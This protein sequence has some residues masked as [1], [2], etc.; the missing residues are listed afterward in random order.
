MAFSKRLARQLKKSF[1]H[2]EFEALMEEFRQTNIGSDEKLVQF[3]ENLKGFLESVDDSYKQNEEKIELAQRSLEV[4]QVELGASN[5]KLFALNQTFDAILNS[6]GQGLVVFDREGNC[7]EIY[8][9]IAEKFF[10]MPPTGKNITQVAGIADE[11]KSTFLDWIKFFFEDLLAPEDVAKLSPLLKIEKDGRIIEIDYRPIRDGGGK[12]V[13][14]LMIATDLTDQ[15]KAE[16]QAVKTQAYAHKILTVTR[17]RQQ[18]V[19]F[20]SQSEQEIK[21]FLDCL[22][23]APGTSV[24]PKEEI[25]RFLHTIKG[26]AGMLSMAELRTLIHTEES[27]LGG[28][29]KPPDVNAQ[30]KHA[31][32]GMKEQFETVKKEIKELLNI[33]PDKAGAMREINESALVT[34]AQTLL[35]GQLQSPQQIYQMFVRDILAEPIFDALKQF[36]LIIANTA[37][38]YG[39]IIKP[40]QFTG[41]NVQILKFRYAKILGSMTHIFTNICVHGIETPEERKAKGKTEDGHVQLTT[42]V[43]QQDK[44]RFYEICVKDDGAGIDPA[45]IRAKITELGRAPELSGKSDADVI[46]YIFDDGFSLAKKAD[47]VA[48]RGVGLAAL[49]ADVKD[50][51]GELEVSSQVNAGTTF[52]IIVPVIE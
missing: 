43:V 26:G 52:K 20:V 50:M 19:Q 7:Q 13:L 15:R 2:D 37:S 10:G 45:R 8:S 21:H 30:F 34:Y 27:R 24:P 33:D 39:K 41:D 42:R 48:G 3:M 23:G 6:L 44:G 17:N 36:D 11:K 35:D 28:L 51:G 38:R 25:L 40:I 22:A 5:S 4:S 12:V 9:K 29:V 31:L 16:E 49:R 18:F 32:V 47:E 46:K 1:E 14:V